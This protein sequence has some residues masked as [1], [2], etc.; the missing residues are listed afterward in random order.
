MKFVNFWHYFEIFVTESL[1]LH[2]NPVE[3]WKIWTEV[4]LLVHPNNP[5]WWPGTFLEFWRTKQRQQIISICQPCTTILL[6]ATL[7]LKRELQSKS[8]TLHFHT[9]R[10]MTSFCDVASL[11]T[12][13]K[14]TSHQL[15]LEQSIIGHDAF[16]TVE[17]P[18][19][20]SINS[21]PYFFIKMKN[22]AKF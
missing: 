10:E 15:G 14:G 17:N 9:A 22:A 18:M 3:L 5:S 2:F 16:G 6:L 11:A 7:K 1:K 21:C 4:A 19:T 12:N 13:K 20:G 8:W